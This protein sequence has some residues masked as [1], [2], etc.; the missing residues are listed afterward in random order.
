MSMH[1]FISD[2]VR[3]TNTI[4]VNPRVLVSVH[5]C[6]VDLPPERSFLALVE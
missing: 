6:R 1:R 3:N 5:V 2:Y 4:K